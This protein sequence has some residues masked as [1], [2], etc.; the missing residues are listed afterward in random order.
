MCAL[1][2]AVTTNAEP[3]RRTVA[4]SQARRQNAVC[5][6]AGRLGMVTIATNMAGRGTDIVLGGGINHQIDAILANDEMSAEQKQAKID[7]LKAEWKVGSFFM[8]ILRSQ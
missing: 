4:R 8:K 1:I 2:T 3:S 6:E 5:V 7:A